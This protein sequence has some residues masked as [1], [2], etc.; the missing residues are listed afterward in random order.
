MEIKFD[1]NATTLKRIGCFHSLLINLTYCWTS[2]RTMNSTKNFQSL[3]STSSLSNLFLFTVLR[4]LMITLANLGLSLFPSSSSRTCC[5]IELVYLLTNSFGTLMALITLD[6]TSIEF[7]LI[8]HPN[9]LFRNVSIMGQFDSLIK[10]DTA[11]KGFCLIRELRF[12]G[13]NSKQRT[14]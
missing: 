12:S 2:S 14:A 5:K 4:K 1:K 9:K 13:I 3:A 6:A 10:D 7:M 8:S 11:K